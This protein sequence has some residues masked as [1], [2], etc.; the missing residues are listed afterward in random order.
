M[1]DISRRVNLSG[2]TIGEVI[3]ILSKLPQEAVVGCCGEPTMFLHVE[4]DKTA[5]SID[6]N[7]LEEY[8]HEN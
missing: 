3:E 1:F 8:Y 2:S 7:D 6:W 5:V 4:D